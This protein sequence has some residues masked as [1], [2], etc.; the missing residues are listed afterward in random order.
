[1]MPVGDGETAPADVVM[2]TQLL[3]SFGLH[4]K[5]MAWVLNVSYMHGTLYIAKLVVR[6]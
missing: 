2:A 1:M 5:E 3:S 6:W 4:P